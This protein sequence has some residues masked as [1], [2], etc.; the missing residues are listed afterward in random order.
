MKR[1]NQMHLPD[2][3]NTEHLKYQP[4]AAQATPCRRP[5]GG[6]PIKQKRSAQPLH[7]ES[8]LHWPKTVMNGVVDMTAVE[9]VSSRA[10][11]EL[12]REH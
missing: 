12:L 7:S 9:D 8:K 1:A 11:P 6:N 2:K 3:P 5:E 4:A 10:G